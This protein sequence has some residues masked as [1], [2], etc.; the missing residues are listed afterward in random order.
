MLSAR[1]R[2]SSS[3]PAQAVEQVRRLVD[4]VDR[5]AVAPVR[6][7]DAGVPGA[8]LD[9]EP[10]VQRAAA[11]VPDVA[12]RRLRDDRRVGADAVAH[13]GDAAG[14]E[15]LLVGRRAHHEVAGQAH[16][17]AGQGGGRERHRAHAALHVARTAAVQQPVAHRADGGS[18]V[19]RSRGSA[20]HDVDVAVEQQAAAAARRR[21]ARRELRPPV[22]AQARPAASA[23]AST[24]S[25]C[26]SQRS[27]VGAVRRE[28]GSEVALQRRLVTRR[29]VEARARSCR[30]R[31]G[32]H[33]APRARRRGRRCRRP[34]AARDGPVPRCLPV[35]RP[36]LDATEFRNDGCRG[37]RRASSGGRAPRAATNPGMTLHA[38]PA[39]P[40]P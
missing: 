28:L 13:G 40:A 12:A 35:T 25:G 7:V 31:S 39:Q 8:A 27:I 34:R 36:A 1:V 4:R 18:L 29:V 26:G 20:R 17:G 24:S 33:E 14:A 10:R 11:G 9:D 37:A 21:E 6:L 3:Q 22:E 23:A 32:R 19:Q 15:R 30:T 16:A 2:H 5:A 38:E